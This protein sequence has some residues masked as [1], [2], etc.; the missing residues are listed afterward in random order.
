MSKNIA[1][2]LKL[3]ETNFNTKKSF[4]ECKQCNCILKTY[5]QIRYNFC[6]QFCFNMFYYNE[7]FEYL[8]LK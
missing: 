7:Y 6:S 8:N 4:L 3:R 5:Y 1:T 2:F